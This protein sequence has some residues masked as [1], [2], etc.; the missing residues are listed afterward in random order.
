MVERKYHQGQLGEGFIRD[1]IDGCWEPWMKIADEILDDED[2]I[3]SV[4]EALRK[5]R[6]K[7]ATRGRKGTPAEVGLRMLALKHMRNWSFDTLSRGSCR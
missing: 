4:Y 7:S 6:P 2:L 3:E 1:S 5:R